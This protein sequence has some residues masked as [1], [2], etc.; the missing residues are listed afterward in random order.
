M[1]GH[2]EH[3]IVQGSETWIPSIPSA[4]FV[5]LDAGGHRWFQMTLYPPDELIARLSAGQEITHRASLD[6]AMQALVAKIDAEAALLAGGYSKVFLLGYSQGGMLSLW[7][8]LKGDRALGGVIAL[9]GAVPVLNI[10]PVSE[11]G[12]NVPIV[13]FHGIHDNVVSIDFARIGKRNSETA[14]S[15]HYTLVDRPGGHD[16]SAGVHRS[17]SDWLAVRV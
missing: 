4:K 9:N 8:A 6:D 11:N 12:K 10:G 7:T 3:M 15:Q 1:G 13:H 5:S 16:P 17:V 2:A 14:G